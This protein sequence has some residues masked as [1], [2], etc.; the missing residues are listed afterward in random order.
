MRKGA[1][2]RYTTSPDGGYQVCILNK[3]RLSS[4]YYDPYLFA[5]VQLSGTQQDRIANLNWPRCISGFETDA[6]TLAFKS[7][8]LQLRSVSGGWGLSGMGKE[9]EHWPAFA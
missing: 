3:E 2:G 7:S 9:S 6:R 8:G 1:S 4:L 5:I